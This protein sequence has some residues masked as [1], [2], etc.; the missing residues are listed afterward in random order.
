VNA[1]VPVLEDLGDLDGKRV[2]VRL[3]LNVPLAKAPDGSW[4]VADDFRI[5]SALPTL[6]WLRDHGAHITACTHLGRPKG[7]RDP[8][9]DVAPVRSRLDELMPGVELLE[10]LRFSPGEEANDPAFVLE[11]VKDQDAYVNDAFGASHRAHASTVGPPAYLPSAAGRL[12]AREVE[13]LTGLLASP[14]RPFVVVV[15]GAKVKDKIGVLRALATRADTVLV[16]GGMAF[17][18]LKALGHGTGASLVDDTHLAACV[19]LLSSS[20]S[21]IVLP[22]DTKALAP[23]HKLTIEAPADPPEPGG[24]GAG[25]SSVIEVFGSEIPDGWRGV[26]IGPATAVLFAEVIASAGTVLWNGPMG[27]FE[28]DRFADGTRAI[29]EAVARC[30]GSTVVGGG[31]SVAALGQLGLAGMVD[32]LSTG[33]GASLELLEFGDLPG[34][35]ALRAAPNART[36]ASATG[37][38]TASSVNAASDL[39]DQ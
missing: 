34:L 5:R 8:Q 12:L 27:V 7:T 17:T 18:F 21:H 22:V 14:A 6:E 13:V 35:A 26:D 10:N 2:L 30:P 15:G 37:G 28:D 19:E 32:H 39:G 3:D 16:G 9:L 31:D 29:A 33:G 38:P 4:V 24:R 23:G 11:L 25:R 36:G 20:S 1:G